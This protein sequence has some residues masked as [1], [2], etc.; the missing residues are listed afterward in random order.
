VLEADDVSEASLA[1]ACAVAVGA[2]DEGVPQ[3]GNP[4]ANARAMATVERNRTTEDTH[5]GITV[6]RP[7]GLPRCRL[8]QGGGFLR[9]WPQ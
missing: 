9:S 4:N 8:I 6:Q 5:I 2:T 3:A 1:R 7:L